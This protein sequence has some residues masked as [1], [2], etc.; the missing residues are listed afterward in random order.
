MKVGNFTIDT[1]RQPN[2]A[3]ITS[4]KYTMNGIIYDLGVL[5][6]KKAIGGKLL[7][8]EFIENLND[9]IIM[10]SGETKNELIDHILNNK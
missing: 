1:F 3:Y 9:N 5:S 6:H 4:F 10:Q 2:V 8:S 7:I